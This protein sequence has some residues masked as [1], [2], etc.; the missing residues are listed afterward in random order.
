QCLEGTRE[1]ILQCLLDDL[2]APASATNV[3]W[4]Y[5]MAGSSKST[6]ATMI[7]EHLRK[8]GQHGAFLFFDRNSPAQSGPD[9][10]IHTLAHQLALSNDV[11]RDVICEAIE[12]DPHI[13][14]TPITSQ[15][16]DLILTPLQSSDR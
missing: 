2:T 5:G 9:G 10:V 13:T 11:L 8:C 4:L 12:R 6:I 3:L 14:T 15:F 16:N 7:A 1:R